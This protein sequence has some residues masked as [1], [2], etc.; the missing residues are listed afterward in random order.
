LG[1]PTNPEREA[2]LLIWHP[3]NIFGLAA[4]PFL[5][6]VLC[7]QRV[8]VPLTPHSLLCNFPRLFFLLPARFEIWE[9][10][11]APLLVP[12]LSRTP[13]EPIFDTQSR[14]R[15]CTNAQASH[16]QSRFA[17]HTHRHS[18]GQRLW[19][20]IHLKDKPEPSNVVRKALE[21]GLRF[22]GS[23]VQG[24]AP[25]SPRWEQRYP[26]VFSMATTSYTHSEK[27]VF[28]RLLA[29]LRPEKG[30]EYGVRRQA[31]DGTLAD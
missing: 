2:A 6:T 26:A 21:S 31:R 8:E 3:V 22:S 1:S 9:A 10:P 11:P 13:K 16:C 20:D 30:Q 17:S 23:V 15:R 25:C 19:R 7:V 24:H 18:R 5:L 4:R 29:S 12:L 27:I 28:P 14:T